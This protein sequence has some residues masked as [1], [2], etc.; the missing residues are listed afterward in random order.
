LKRIG[1]KKKKKRVNVVY[2]IV[3]YASMDG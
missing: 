3:D 2:L 1:N